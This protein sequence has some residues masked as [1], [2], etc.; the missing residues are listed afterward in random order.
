MAELFYIYELKGLNGCKSFNPENGSKFFFEMGN[1]NFQTLKTKKNYT[2][3]QISILP[4]VSVFLCS[5][6]FPSN[7]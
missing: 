5:F 6:S 2:A 1:V 4:Q 3:A 7:N